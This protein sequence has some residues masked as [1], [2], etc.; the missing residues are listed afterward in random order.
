PNTV[1]VPFVVRAWSGSQTK[2]LLV[3]ADATYA[4]YNDWGGRNVYGFATFG[5]PNPANRAL[6]FRGTFPSSSGARAP[7]AFE[8][9]FQRPVGYALG[10]WPP[11]LEVPMIQ[12]LMRRGIPVDVYT[13][14]DL[15][16]QAP[17]TMDYRLLLFIGHH[18]YWTWEMRDH[19]ENF[20]TA[21]GAVGF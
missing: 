20:V 13:A 9:S 10:N 8:L 16:F 21:G 15:H 1:D 4:A 19:V 18:E 5:D 6:G 2:I 17:T 3:I 14:R 7:Y 12:W 11:G